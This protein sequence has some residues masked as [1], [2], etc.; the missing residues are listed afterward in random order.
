M[1]NFTKYELG[2]LE[3][4]ISYPFDKNKKKTLLMGANVYK[5]SHVIYDRLGGVRKLRDQSIS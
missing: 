4:N 1:I 3:K 2:W 5:P